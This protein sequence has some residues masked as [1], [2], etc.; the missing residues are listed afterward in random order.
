ML[1]VDTESR[2]AAVFLEA[3]GRADGER[4]SFLDSACAGE[5]EVRSRVA[6][7]LAADARAAGFLESA[8][9]AEGAAEP[10][11]GRRVGRYTIARLIGRGGMGAVY[12][13]AQRD[14]ER[15]VA[16]KIMSPWLVSR[17]ALRRFADESRAL[18]RLRHP[19]IVQVY[20]TGVWRAHEG[21]PEVPYFAMEFVPA[22]RSIVRYAAE[23]RLDRRAR[24]DLF[25]RVCDAVGHGH[26]HGIIHRDLKPANIVVDAEG[27]PK[28]I[29][30]GGAW[31]AGGVAA[32]D[33]NRGEPRLGTPARSMATGAGHLIGTP[34]YMSPEQADGDG[35][36]ADT[37]SD[38]YGLGAVLY[39]L[40]TGRP[41]LDLSRAGLAQLARLIRETPPARPSSIDRSLRGDLETIVLRALEKDPARRYQAA[42]DLG[43]DVRRL[44]AHQPIEARPPTRLYLVSKFARRHRAG[45]AAAAVAAAA[46][47]AGT[48]VATWQAIR[49]TRAETAAQGDRLVAVRQSER[50][51]TALRFVTDALFA[52]PEVREGREERILRAMDDM[53]RRV[54]AGEFAEEPEIEEQ[55]RAAL[56]VSYYKFGL[57]QRAIP[58]FL[59]LAES[60]SEEGAERREVWDALRWLAGSTIWAGSADAGTVA[61]CERTVASARRL[62]G[63]ED[64][65]TFISVQLLGAAQRAVGRLDRAEDLLNEAVAGLTR[66]TGENSWQTGF[67]KFQLAG[68]CVAINQRERAG[69]LCR[70][71]IGAYERSLG[72]DALGTLVAQRF[73]ADQVLSPQGHASEAEAILGGALERSRRALGVGHKETLE[74]QRVL[75][76]TLCRRG[77]V[78]ECRSLWEDLIPR[79]ASAH[80]PWHPSTEAAVRAALAGLAAMGE[81][82]H[83]ILL[84]AQWAPGDEARSSRRLAQA[85]E[86]LIGKGE[87]ATAER[88]LRTSVEIRARVM[89]DKW[90]YF[91]A[92]SILGAAVAGQGRYAEAEPM[93]AD[94]YRGMAEKPAGHPIF[95]IQAARRLVDLYERWGKPNEAEEWR[96]TLL[97]L[98][99]TASAAE[100]PPSSGAAPDEVTPDT[101]PPDSGAPPR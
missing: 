80:G 73:Y 60:R 56:G 7:L 76:E 94:G 18:A 24:L 34:G 81:S 71:T 32:G 84:S 66:T 28:V 67:A 97:A 37:R 65:R 23:E 88:L 92:L 14:P 3:V 19:G 87:H 57:P 42:A 43:R 91:H 29:D 30:F 98:E 89:P 46:L 100:P 6:A 69:R 54:E 44:L 78:D 53:A 85:G 47:V 21:E 59:W 93:L 101:D 39:E 26:A 41:P 75:A 9:D 86:V 83:A 58:H 74:T 82:D 11:V 22:A 17:D 55:I 64:A 33:P 10:M 40:L 4:E 51:R 96:A 48:G 77:A 27:R 72:P 35:H 79:M 38:V 99:R 25:A 52:S 2:A 20:E 8:L 36:A 31:A 1:A 12:E 50:T 15:T 16:L 13:A 63:N 61:M 45:V 90:G 62:F 70:E 68:L 49:A 95:Q 5:P